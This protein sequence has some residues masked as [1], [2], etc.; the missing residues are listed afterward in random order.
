MKKI[1]VS[2][3]TIQ[4]VLKEDPDQCYYNGNVLSYVDSDAI[5]FM[6]EFGSSMV[7]IGYEGWTHFDLIKY[8]E[9]DHIFID[10]NYRNGKYWLGRFWSKSKVISFWKLPD[11]KSLKNIIDELSDFFEDE[12]DFSSYQLEVNNNRFVNIIEYINNEDTETT[13][14]DTTKLHLMKPEDK[15]KTPQM[16]NA[17]KTKYDL[18]GKKLGKDN[19][20]RSITQAEYNF[21][22]RYGLGESSNKD[23][24]LDN[25]KQKKELNPKLWINNKINS[26]VRLRLLDI[27]DD[28]LKECNLSWIKPKDIILTGSMANY[29]W[30]KYSDIDVHVVIDYKDVFDDKDIVEDYF[31]TKKNEWTNNHDNLTIYGYPVEI[32]VQ[33][34][35]EKLYDGIFSLENNEWIQKPSFDEDFDL[36]EDKIK[37]VSTKYMNKIDEMEK[38]FNENPKESSIKKFKNLF[39]TLKNMRKDSLKSKNNVGDIVYKV[40]RR[41]GYLDKLY[42]LKI[43]SY[44]KLKSLS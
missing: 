38:A 18:I 8:L 13:N 34:K 10:K 24:N 20:S 30:S 23:I 6:S 15:I 39:N 41:N 17:L 22:K 28:F 44:D 27:A 31:I 16:K 1:I 32:F 11:K 7:Y 12:I 19:N 21:Y 3:H 25:F 4:N 5:P 42:K 2:K 35:N 9:K 43:E 14:F 37:K 36:N 29:N 40:L 33:D 26:N